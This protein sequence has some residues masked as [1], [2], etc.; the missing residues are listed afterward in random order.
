MGL[1]KLAKGANAILAS[2]Q[3]VLSPPSTRLIFCMINEDV[4]EQ[5]YVSFM[6]KRDDERDVNPSTV[7]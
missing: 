5:V 3:A 2:D 6:V 7:A 1:W 4:E